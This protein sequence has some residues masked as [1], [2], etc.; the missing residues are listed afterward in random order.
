MIIEKVKVLVNDPKGVFNKIFE[1]DLIS[2]FELIENSSLIA[3]NLNDYEHFVYVVYNMLEL[4]AFL[5]LEKMGSTIL[6]CLF[7][8]SLSI[9][10][11]FIEEINDLIVLDSYKTRKT[12]TKDLKLYLKN[13]SDFTKQAAESQTENLYKN[14]TEC[15]GF[16]KTVCLFI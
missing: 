14:Q 10:A 2:E 15:H 7:S 5:K 13:T 9:N 4:I 8:K 3:N 16:F 12:I 1:K 6:V 11:T